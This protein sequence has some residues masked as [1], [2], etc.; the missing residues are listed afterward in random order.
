[1]TNIMFKEMNYRLL[2]FL[3]LLFGTKVLQADQCWL[4]TDYLLWTTKKAPLPLPLVTSASLDDPLPGA[5]GQPGTKILLGDEKIAMQWQNGF[6]V[7]LG[8]WI[9]P[10]QHLGIEGSFFMLP[11]KTHRQSE[12]TSGA[13]GSINIAVPI[14]DVTGL[15]GLNGVPGETVFILPGPLDGPGFQGRFSLKMSSKLLGAELNSLVN[16]INT[17]EFKLDLLCGF[18]WVQLQESLL[19]RGKTDALPNAPIAAG[20]YNFKDN[21]KTNNNFYAL[22]I[23]LKADCRMDKWCFNGVAKLALG[24]MDQKVRIDG[25]SQTLDGN[26]FYMTKNTGDEILGGGIFSEPTNRGSHPHDKFAVALE[27]G[28]NLSYQFSH[29]FEIG[30]GYNILW[31]NQVLRPGDQ[32]DRKIN[33]TRTALAEASRESV[34]IGPDTPVPFGDSAAAPLPTG[35]RRPKFKHHSTDFWA[36]GLTISLNLKF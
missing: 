25:K 12:R 7:A 21:F 8:S 27:T 36:H 33:P 2:F 10:C 24:Y 16:W 13:P 35:P 9:D 34:G 31:L 5:L 3:I 15:W 1:M 22:Q 23:G 26:L 32:I 18:R 17:S 28:V 19:F 20:F 4:E 6:R 29:C 14:F 11:N 30:V